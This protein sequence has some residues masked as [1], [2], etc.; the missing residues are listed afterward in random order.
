MCVPVVACDPWLKQ[1]YTSTQ[2]NAQELGSYLQAEFKGLMATHKII[3]DVRGLGMMLGI[4]LVTDR[5][6]GGLFVVGVCTCI[7]TYSWG[8]VSGTYTYVYIYMH[9][10]ISH[11]PTKP[12]TTQRAQEPGPR[13]GRPRA[14]P[15]AGLGRA[16]PGMVWY[17]RSCLSSLKS[18][19]CRLTCNPIRNWW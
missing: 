11:R 9:T 2:A 7:S 13:G 14:A 15:C 3:G 10:F 16:H 18:V 8:F 1:I 17:N 19:R 6:V 12:E 5:W 4:E